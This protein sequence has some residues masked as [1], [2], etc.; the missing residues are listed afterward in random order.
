MKKKEKNMAYKIF[1]DANVIL[2]LTLERKGHK[3]AEELFTKINS[4]TFRAYISSSVLHILFYILSKEMSV[5]T[6]KSIILNCLQEVDIIDL[7]KEVAINAINSRITDTEDALQYYVALHH[8]MDYFIS[9][10]KKLKKESIPSLPVKT[11]LEFVE[12]FA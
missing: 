11:T 1:I 5:A 6:T 4:G 2:D 12:T 3:E 10:D 9:N 8:K 7:D